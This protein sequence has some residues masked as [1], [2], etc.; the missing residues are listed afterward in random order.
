MTSVKALVVLL[1]EMG[2]DH[3]EAKHLTIILVE[4]VVV[5]LQRRHLARGLLPVGLSSS[6][7][8]MVEKGLQILEAH[9]VDDILHR[10]RS[11]KTSSI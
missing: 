9:T 3:P 8:Q 10:N 1:D 5:H 2:V 7:D 6:F 4:L 11:A